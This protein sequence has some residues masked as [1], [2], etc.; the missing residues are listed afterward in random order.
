MSL[1]QPWEDPMLLIKK[2]EYLTNT[3][4]VNNNG[5]MWFERI[6]KI[7]EGHYN[8]FLYFISSKRWIMW[9]NL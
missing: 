6:K 7:T 3:T 9:Y 4:A 2:Q 1:L 5:A 8:L